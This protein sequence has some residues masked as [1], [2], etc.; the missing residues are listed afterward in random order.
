MKVE[1]AGPFLWRI[2]PDAKPGMRVPGL[3]VA[4]ETLMAAIRKDASLEQVANGA[5]LPG[6]VKASLA[7]PDIHQGYG[8]PVGGVI[9]SDADEGVVSPG[10]IGFDINCGVRL[11][12]AP[13]AAADLAPR[14]E[15]LVD[16]L[17]SAIPAGVGSH[18]KT[19]LD[20]RALRA[21][22]A[23]GAAWAVEEG[24]GEA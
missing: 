21:V 10:G 12:A 20:A 3:V 2:P 22:M 4:D 18:G 11:L 8:L 13:I 6:L 16:A 7:M 17:A 24:F 15:S 23:R 14:M 9:A 19:T 1:R 5:T